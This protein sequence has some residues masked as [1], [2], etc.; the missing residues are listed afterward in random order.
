[1]KQISRQLHVLAT[2]NRNHSSQQLAVPDDI[3]F[4]RPSS[5][6]MSIVSHVSA[7]P[8]P[9]AEAPDVFRLD[10]PSFLSNMRGGIAPIALESPF[11]VQHSWPAVASV[12]MTPW[13][14]ALSPL[15]PLASSCSAQPHHSAQEELP[16]QQKL[17]NSDRIAQSKDAEIILLQQKQLEKQ[18]Q[19]LND[20]I[21]LQQKNQQLLEMNSREFHSSRIPQQF[22]SPRSKKE[23]SDAV[24]QH[25]YEKVEQLE[26]GARTAQHSVLREAAGSSD[27]A[28]VTPAAQPRAHSFEMILPHSAE[29]VVAPTRNCNQ[30]VLIGNRMYRDKRGMLRNGGPQ[31]LLNWDAAA[32]ICRHLDSVPHLVRLSQTC[33]FFKRVCQL[34]PSLWHTIDVTP[35]G[36]FE[37]VMK[38]NFET[39]MTTAN[40]AALLTQRCTDGD[41]LAFRASAVQVVNDELMPLLAKKSH[42]LKELDLSWHNDAGPAVTDSGVVAVIKHAQQLVSFKV[43]CVATLTDAALLALSSYCRSLVQLDVSGIPGISDVGIISICESNTG[44]LLSHLSVY[45]CERLTDSS[46][47]RVARC[48]SSLVDVNIGGCSRV[49]GDAVVLLCSTCRNLM[50]LNASGLVRLND[51]HVFL[52][53]RRLLQLQHLSLAFCR[54]VGAEAL[55]ALT[56]NH[57][58]LAIDPLLINDRGNEVFHSP[59]APAVSVISAFNCHSGS[60]SSL[61]TVTSCAGSV[62]LCQEA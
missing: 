18:Q 9:Q 26:Q 47:M 34:T 16:N 45:G 17:S 22:S 41:L 53:S 8:Q 44:P 24:L 10:T 4:S 43:G 35:V 52:A 56:S 1:M 40:V 11:Q 28:A 25:I 54:N 29:S 33:V 31:V 23:S 37:A 62:R 13:G 55:S 2:W 42:N 59:I 7:P 27:P 5:A 20:L 6:Y 57:P 46:L 21:S 38:S 30:G 58:P 14:A 36:G 12:V 39:R 19:L 49:S 32:A 15:P 48:C 3:S 50:K 61:K 60:S 51:S